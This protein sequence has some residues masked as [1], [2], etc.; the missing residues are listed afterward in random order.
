MIAD[1]Q[2]QSIPVQF[3]FRITIHHEDR[4]CHEHTCDHGKHLEEREPD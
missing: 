1:K 4:P 3:R 2:R